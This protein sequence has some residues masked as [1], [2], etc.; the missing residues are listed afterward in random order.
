M[1]I[2]KL[3]GFAVIA[4]VLIVVIK[5]Q[6]KEIAL[7][8]SVFTAIA[9]IAYAMTQM[10][11]V[12]TMLESLIEKSGISKDFMLIIFKVI[13]I[14]YLVEFGKNICMDAGQSAIATKLEMAGKVM[15]VV[16]SVPLINALLSVIAG[17][18]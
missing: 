12:I 8:L 10:S 18:V 15:I 1:D 4:T 9:I 11:G 13:G 7:I 14:A 16:L 6:R 3:L 17:M 2:F 5:E